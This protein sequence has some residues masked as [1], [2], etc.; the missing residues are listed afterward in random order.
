[1]PD[2]TPRRRVTLCEVTD[3]PPLL[4][5]WVALR[6]CD[7]RFLPGDPGL[8]IV[9]AA[10]GAC[11]YVGEADDLWKRWRGHAERPR[12]RADGAAWLMYIVYRAGLPARRWH[13]AQ[14]IQ[15]LN[16]RH[17][18][19]RPRRRNARGVISLSPLPMRS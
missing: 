4:G 12:L 7:H 13:E 1:M 18:H 9:G 11:L 5:S 17:G 6:F 2:T 3:P 8:Y 19:G 10:D 14:L 16:P 15:K